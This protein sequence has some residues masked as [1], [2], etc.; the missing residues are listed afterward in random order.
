M[1]VNGFPLHCPHCGGD[2]F[3]RT[4]VSLDSSRGMFLG[5]DWTD[6]NVSAF[7]CLTCGR[8]EWFRG[9]RISDYDRR[10]DADCNRCGTLI[11]ANADVCPNCGEPK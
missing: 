6:E 4:Q 3:E 5:L 11:P 2:S 7:T 1:F 10:G 8:M 9:A